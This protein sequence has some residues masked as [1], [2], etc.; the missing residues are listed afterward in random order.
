M[1]PRRPTPSRRDNGFLCQPTVATAPGDS[2]DVLRSVVQHHPRIDVCAGGPDD[3]AQVAIHFGL[4]LQL[5]RRM[6]PQRNPVAPHL[7]QHGSVH[8]QQR[9]RGPT[10]A[11]RSCLLPC[12]AAPERQPEQCGHSVKGR[13]SPL[14]A[15]SLPAFSRIA[16]K[17]AAFARAARSWK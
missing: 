15:A 12:Y 10:G 5:T 11:G 6:Q 2:I 14:M 1:H 3:G 9:D 8:A 13:S 4:G 16:K 17:S 7:H